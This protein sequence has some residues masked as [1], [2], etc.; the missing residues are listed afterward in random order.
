MEKSEALKQASIIVRL[1]GTTNNDKNFIAVA[2]FLDK[3]AKV[4]EER[5][6]KEML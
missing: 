2:V 4:Y 5:A 3:L 6:S 1:L